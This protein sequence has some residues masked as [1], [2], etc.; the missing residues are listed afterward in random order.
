MDARPGLLRN[1]LPV[2]ARVPRV[3]PVG[4]GLARWPAGLPRARLT[5]TE[6]AAHASEVP[7]SDLSL[8]FHGTMQSTIILSHFA[9]IPCAC[10]ILI[11]V[12]TGDQ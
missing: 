9:K 10:F 5:A 11:K 1:P 8:V 4:F 3:A 6:R 12:T 7:P 2:R